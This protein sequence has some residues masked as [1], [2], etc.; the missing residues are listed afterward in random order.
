MS[1]DVK[2]RERETTVK[3]KTFTCWLVDAAWLMENV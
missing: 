2:V 1:N 3:G